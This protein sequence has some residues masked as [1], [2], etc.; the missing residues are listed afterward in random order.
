MFRPK[1][2]FTYEEVRIIVLALIELKNQLIEEGRYTDSVDDLLI[3][4]V[5]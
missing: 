4:L 2:K 5:D 3:R 1:Y